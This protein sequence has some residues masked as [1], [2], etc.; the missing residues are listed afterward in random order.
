MQSG[1]CFYQKRGVSVWSTLSANKHT[2]ITFACDHRE[3]R[4]PDFRVA[5][6]GPPTACCALDSCMS[7]PAKLRPRSAAEQRRRLSFANPTCS[8]GIVT[9]KGSTS[10]C[11]GRGQAGNMQSIGCQMV[12][13]AL[14]LSIMW[15]DR[16]LMYHVF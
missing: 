2:P 10:S 1:D 11:S 8:G 16:W 4:P 5:F 3:G 7:T 6:L 13:H 12:D 9:L 15:V 14:R